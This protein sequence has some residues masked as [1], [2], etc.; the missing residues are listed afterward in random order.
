MAERPLSLVRLEG[1][2]VV[3]RTTTI[4]DAP[5]YLRYFDRNRAHLEPWESTHDPIFYTEPFWVERLA[6]HDDERERGTMLR[7][8]IFDRDDGERGEIAGM[9]GLTQIQARAPVWNARVGYSL[10]ASKEGRGMMSEALALVVRYSFDVLGLK[11]LLA[12][13]VPRNTRSAKVLAR[14]GFVKE[15]YYREFLYLNGVWEDHV[16]TSLINPDWRES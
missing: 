15:G 4:A 13:Y 1:A 10:D 6:S 3:V 9:L 2:R 5:S 8:S 14:A 16:E 12:G 11:R 7:L